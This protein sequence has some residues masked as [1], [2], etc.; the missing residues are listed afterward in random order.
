MLLAVA[1]VLLLLHFRRFPFHDST[2][3][4]I[5]VHAEQVSKS[6]LQH[7]I[8]KNLFGVMRSGHFMY[9]MLRGREVQFMESLALRQLI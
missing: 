2:G 7:Y 1:R 5:Y 3:F 6:K 8:A 4:E 9:N